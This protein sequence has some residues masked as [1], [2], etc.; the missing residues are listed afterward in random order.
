M[1]SLPKDVQMRVLD[2]I[3]H[4]I[5]KSYIL[6]ITGGAL[7]AIVSLAMRR[8]KLFGATAGIAAA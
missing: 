4:A 1:Q 5:D 3:V 8:E 2:A 7:V 6:V